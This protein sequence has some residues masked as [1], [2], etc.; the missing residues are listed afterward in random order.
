LARFVR[1]AHKVLGNQDDWAAT[2]QELKREPQLVATKM[3]AQADLRS[4][5][6]RALSKGDF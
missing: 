1:R 2:L 6:R 4:E 5:L 3:E